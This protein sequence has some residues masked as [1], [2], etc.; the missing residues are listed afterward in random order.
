M[1]KTSLTRDV[2]GKLIIRNTFCYADPEM[3]EFFT[4]HK[5]PVLKVSM[6]WGQRNTV[7]LQQSLKPRPF[8]FLPQHRRT[9]VSQ[10]FNDLQFFQPM[11]PHSTGL[12]S[13]YWLR[14]VY[15]WP[16]FCFTCCSLVRQCQR[17]NFDGLSVSHKVCILKALSC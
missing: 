9:S 17:R 7:G 5:F 11:V 4:L 6:A 15:R 2:V 8:K 10:E 1:F 13:C 14:E 3:D 16:K 12:L